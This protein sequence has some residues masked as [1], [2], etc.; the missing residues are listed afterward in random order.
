[1][2]EI[3]KVFVCFHL[4]DLRSDS[5]PCVVNSSAHTCWYC[6]EHDWILRLPLCSFQGKG[7]SQWYLCTLH[8]AVGQFVS[9]L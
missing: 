9:V 8:S 3:I 5:P 6:R 7:L 4:K 2:Q 1:M